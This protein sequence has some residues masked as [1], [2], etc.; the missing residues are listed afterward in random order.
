MS[1]ASRFR[2]G[3]APASL[4]HDRR[5]DLEARY[6]MP[7]RGGNAPASLKRGIMDALSTGS[8]FLP[9]RKRPGLI[10]APMV[11]APRLPMRT[12]RGGNAPASLKLWVEHLKLQEMKYLPGRKRPGLIEATATNT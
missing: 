6:E 7:F 3:N 9:G 4:K 11:S 2:G 5:W 10:E 12:F 8:P 1:F